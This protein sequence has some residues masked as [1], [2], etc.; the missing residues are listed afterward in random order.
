MVYTV[1]YLISRLANSS[2]VGINTEEGNF[3]FH[4]YDNGVFVVTVDG[5][6]CNWSVKEV[7][8]D[9]ILDVEGKKFKFV[10]EGDKKLIFTDGIEN[11]EFI[12]V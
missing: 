3:T 9:L 5:R 2:F 7:A 6:P 12:E 8:K 4:N 1:D 10:G 11:I